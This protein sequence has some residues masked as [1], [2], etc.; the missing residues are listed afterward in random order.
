MSK[1]WVPLPWKCKQQKIQQKYLVLQASVKVFV[2]T[3]NSITILG[4]E[5]KKFSLIIVPMIINKNLISLD[6]VAKIFLNSYP[7]VHNLTTSE[8]VWCKIINR[9]A[10]IFTRKHIQC[11]FQKSDTRTLNYTKIVCFQENLIHLQ[12]PQPKIFSDT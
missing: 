8:Q 1:F 7:R 12:V 5:Q 10:K 9:T 11:F 3:Y 2:C 6:T 4:C